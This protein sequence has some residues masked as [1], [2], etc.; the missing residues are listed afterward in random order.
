ME[1]LEALEKAAATR[2][3]PANRPRMYTVYIDHG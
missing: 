1:A 3:F 2:A